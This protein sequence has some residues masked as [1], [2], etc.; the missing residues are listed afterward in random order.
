MKT[1]P[2]LI[3]D[4]T[5]IVYRINRA[6]RTSIIYE[7]NNF[8]YMRQ[9]KMLLN[10]IK[11]ALKS[12][13]KAYLTLKQN[14]MQFNGRKLKFSYSDYHI[15]K[16][17][18][19]EF[20]KKEIGELSF[21]PGITKEELNTFIVLLAK[22]DYDPKNPY[23]DFL[24]ELKKKDIK[25]IIAEKIPFYEKTKKKNRDAK[26]VFFM[27]ITHLKEIFQSHE[28]LQD[29]ISLLTTK[30]LMQSLFNHITENESFIH[31][32]TNIKNFDEYTLNH[33]VN[34]CILSIS[35]GKKLGLDRNE[36]VD[37]G[38]AAFLHDFG[39]LDIPKDILLKPGKLDENERET[40]EKHTFYGAVKLID[41]KRK[42]HLPLDALNVA[43]EHH[44]SEGKRGYPKLVKKR[45]IALFSKIVKITDVF[46]AMTTSRPYR[47]HN[48]SKEEALS[49]MLE[50][51]SGDFDSV[52]LKIFADMVGVCPIGSLVLLDTGEVGIVFE[53]NEQSKHF[54]R[55]KVKL[56]SDQSGNKID[57]D[58]VDLTEK[59]KN[60]KYLRTLI[61]TLDESQYG[62]RTA[63]Y[64]VAEAE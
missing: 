19:E 45:A 28:K 11:N 12:Y 10:Q 51:G 20:K 59:D 35:L 29:Q 47:K 32:L 1:D 34:V 6:Y 37:L 26:K 36:L 38:L 50:K 2:K 27:G 3:K 8:I 60:D 41:F 56:I 33:S 16:F 43:L 31:G 24:S 42:S 9:I 40:I 64:F 25:K 52:I 53:R 23:E 22:K 4:G 18:Q 48:F 7:S 5:R 57:G 15:F 62:I 17:I 46:D 14:S 44:E 13:G 61:K 55:P 21:I 39:K 58:I 63:D 54:L 30:R 49:Y